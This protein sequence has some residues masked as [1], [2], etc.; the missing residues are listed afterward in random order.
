MCLRSVTMNF[1][2]YQ[3]YTGAALTAYAKVLLDCMLGDQT[4][5]WRQDGVELCWKFLT[6]LLEKPS[7]ERLF[8]YK[9]GTWGPQEAGRFLAAHGLVP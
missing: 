1:N 7:A 8:L 5:F 6:P 3:G 4:L 2:Y 9:S